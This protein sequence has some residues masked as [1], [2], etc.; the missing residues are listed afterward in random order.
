MA[1]LVVVFFGL[2]GTGKTT[3]AKALGAA[4]NL[5]VI[6]SDAVRKGLAGLRPTTPTPEE[7]GKGIYDE[8][9]SRRTY[10]EMRRLAQEH[11]AAGRGVILDASYKRAQEREL[12]RQ[13]AQEHGAQVA[14]VC[15]TCPLEVVKERLNRRAHNTEAISDGRTALLAAQA[16]DFDPLEAADQ[17][18]LKLDTSREKQL[19][20]KEL[21][22]FIT[23]QLKEEGDPYATGRS[24]GPG[25][26]ESER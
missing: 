19:A 17:P 10:G 11:L 22:D 13:L 8:D 14:F 1:L 9:F 24:S 15:C 25:E 5:P 23:Q 3:Q 18:L 6:H 16:Q 26:A 7:F 20:T 21:L 4:L 12:V 2:M